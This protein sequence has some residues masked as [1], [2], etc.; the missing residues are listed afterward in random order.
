MTPELQE[1][2]AKIARHCWRGAHWVKAPGGPRCVKEP[3]K[4]AHLAAHVGGKAGVGLAPITPGESTTRIAVLDFDSHKGEVTWEAMSE[5]VREVIRVLCEGEGMPRAPIAFRSSGGKGIHV[6]MLWDEPQDA[7]SVRETLARALSAV[8]LK[9]GTK[10]VKHGEVEIFPKQDSVP[11]GGFGNM[12]ILPLTGESLPLDPFTLELKG[13]EYAEDIG[14]WPKSKSVPVLTRPL[15]TVNPSSKIDPASLSTSLA[16]V[17]SALAAIPNEAAESLSYDDWRNVV[18]AIHNASGGSDEGLA[19][20]HEFSARSPK[21]DADFLTERVWPY[22]KDERGGAIITAATLFGRA[23]QH[24]WNDD[25][26]AEFEDLGTLEDQP[27]PEHSGV[28]QVSGRAQ[29]P[30]QPSAASA[31]PGRFRSIHVSDFAQRPQPRWIIRN[32]LPEAELV[33]VYG[34]SGSGK[35]FFAFDMLAAIAQEIPWRGRKTIGGPCLYICAEGAG[36]FRNRLVGY[37]LHSG[38]DLSQLP[39]RV[40]PDAPNLLVKDDVKELVREAKAIGEVR[41]IVVDTFAQVTAGGDENSGEDVGRAIANCKALHRATGALVVLI[42]HAGK[43]LSKGA[44]GHSSLKAAADAEIE[45]SRIESSRIAKIT[46]LKDGADG[47]ALPFKLIVIQVG[48]DEDG[49]IIDSCAVE[50]LDEAEE[51]ATTRQPAGDVARLVWQAVNDLALLGGD[52]TTVAAIIEESI[53]GMATDPAK[54]DRRREV[55]TRALQ[56]LASTGWVRIEDGRVLV[57]GNV[58]VSNH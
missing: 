46:K 34:E 7:Y 32:V 42:H 43:D 14:D 19:I 18:F 23:R 45:I 3:L 37:S 2:V 5:K 24:G 31:T 44:R 49:G 28:D 27:A 20:A 11:L 26:L 50:H 21:Y 58:N 41:V 51:S 55:A 16:E 1:A 36:G 22:I 54:R 30:G 29:A 15:P 13:Y 6:V 25:V 10:G 38:V 47:I 52:E 17:R 33:V 4:K 57:R 39:I 53:K 9:S 48:K 12:F 56:G 35:S 40:I 8:G